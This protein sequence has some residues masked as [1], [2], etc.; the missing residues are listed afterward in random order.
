MFDGAPGLS[1]MQMGGLVISNIR[2][3]S[4]RDW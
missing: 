2:R 3:D 1:F 4:S